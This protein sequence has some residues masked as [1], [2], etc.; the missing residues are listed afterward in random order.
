MAV[1][2]LV[3]FA[4]SDYD[5]HTFRIPAL[6]RSHSGALLALAEGRRHARRDDGEIDLV[7]KRSMDGGESWSELQVVVAEDGM[8]CG[9]PCPVQVRETGVIWLTF[10]KNLAAGGEDLITQGKAPRTVWITRSDDDGA[11]WSEPVE[12]TTQVKRPGWSW[13]ATGPGHGVQLTSGRL[14]IPCDHIVAKHFDRQQDPHHSHLIISDD[15]GQSWRIGGIL[16]VG[17]NECA[18]VETMDGGIYINAR[19]YSGS[20]CR[21]VAWSADGGEQFTGYQEDSQLVEPVCQASLTRFSG[22]GDG[23]PSRILFANP[24]SRARERM[25]VRLSYDEGQ[26]W[27]HSRLLYHGLAAYSDL[28]VLPDGRIC[29]LY[30]RGEEHPYEQLVLARFTLEW[31]TQGEDRG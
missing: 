23:R 11:S 15:L 1:D 30:E 18:V 6:W 31:L 17:T 5:Y 19:N 7:L 24:A 3:L 22:I 2:E 29:C 26:S 4:R 25:S 16:P 27:P 13:Y 14:V 9:N 12:I 8:T 10:C 21:A 20:Y 28:A